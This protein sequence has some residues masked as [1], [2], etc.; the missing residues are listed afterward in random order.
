MEGWGVCWLGV[1]VGVVVELSIFVLEL[2]V[3]L[4]LGCVALGEK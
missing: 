4:I 2:K 3:V 1:V